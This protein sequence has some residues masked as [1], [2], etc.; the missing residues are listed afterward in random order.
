MNFR[1]L[2][3]MAA[4]S[5]I[6]AAAPAQAHASRHHH[7]HHHHGMTAKHDRMADHKISDS[8]HHNN[9]PTAPSQAPTSH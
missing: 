2:T 8:D 9:D 7:H 3:T 4:C 1:V 6:A 5:V